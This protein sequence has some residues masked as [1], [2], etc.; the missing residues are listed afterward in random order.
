MEIEVPLRNPRTFSDI[1]R[2]GKP[3][4]QLETVLM[5]IFYPAAEQTGHGHD[6]AGHKHWS[7]ATWLPRPRVQMAQGYG[8]FA[9]M[10][11]VA[12]PWFAATTMLTK[13]PAF[14]NAHPARHWPP[15]QDA[16]PQRRPREDKPYEDPLPE[17]APGPEPCF[18]LMIFSH[19]LGGT[20][21][22]Y[23][24]ICGEFASYGFVVCAIEHRDGSGPRTY[25]HRPRKPQ[26][27]AGDNENISSN[28]IEKVN[29]EEI[30]EFARKLDYTWPKGNPYDTSPNNDK[31]IDR[32]LRLG[33]IELRLAE[34]EEA[35]YVLSEI[36]RGNGQEI[37]D[38]NLRRK[39][40]IGG[41]SRGL[42][43]V[44]WLEWQ[45]RFDL[46]NVT[47]TGH[48][49]G[50]ATTVNVLRRSE[51]FGFISQGLIYDIWG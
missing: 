18:P 32:E 47:M 40:S 27:T 25:V 29:P 23:S 24:M 6:P 33:Q 41:S 12:V 10:G 44:N 11:N 43:G 19:G 42:D 46:K 49:F 5:T 51:T 13:L 16:M 20:R 17:N 26:R 2:K 3:I 30:E 7:R 38:K 36:C 9:G 50:A 45:G 37:A 8:K 15:Q 31:G 28:E 39:G 14:R 1:K 34:I 4:L 48:S 21:T 22:A 35:Y